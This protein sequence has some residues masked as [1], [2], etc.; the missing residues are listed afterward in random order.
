MT[1]KGFANLA[2]VSH[3]RLVLQ[4]LLLLLSP[5][6]LRGAASIFLNLRIPYIPEHLRICL[7]IQV[8]GNEFNFDVFVF[9]ISVS[10]VI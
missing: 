3:Q 9:I 1:L 8:C 7:E 10:N 4:E 2:R 5:V 6:E